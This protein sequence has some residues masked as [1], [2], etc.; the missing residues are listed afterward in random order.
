MK[1]YEKTISHIC[2]IYKSKPYINNCHEIG[3]QIIIN[4]KKFL[5]HTRG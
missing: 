1:K 3:F 4:E 5:S 2:V